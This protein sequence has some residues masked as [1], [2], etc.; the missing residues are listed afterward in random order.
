LEE[1]ERFE[2]FDS[3][4]DISIDMIFLLPIEGE[5]G[6]AFSSGPG[7][8]SQ[9]VTSSTGPV[10]VGIGTG[11]R[12]DVDGDASPTLGDSLAVLVVLRL[13]DVLRCLGAG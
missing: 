1:P 2:V 8:N 3:D 6:D 4:L 13:A 5:V 12:L 9:G 11:C 7:A 10:F